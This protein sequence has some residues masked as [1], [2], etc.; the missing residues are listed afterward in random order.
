VFDHVLDADA[1]GQFGGIV[2][3]G[4][5]AKDYFVYQIE[6]NFLIG[7]FQG[8]CSVVSRKNDDDFFAFVHA[9]Q[10][11]RAKIGKRIL[12]IKTWNGGEGEI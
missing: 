12:G 6:W 3:A 10:I 11:S 9:F 4:V 5:I 1:A 8:A 7:F 2:F